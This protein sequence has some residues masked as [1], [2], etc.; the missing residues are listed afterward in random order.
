[1]N[2]KTREQALEA[3]LERAMQWLGKAHAE[4]IHTTCCMPN[5]LQRTIKLG[6]TALAMPKRK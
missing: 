5:D 4:G 3:A 1:M 2:E 6:A